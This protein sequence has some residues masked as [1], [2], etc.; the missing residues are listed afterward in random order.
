MGVSI[1][2]FAT[3]HGDQ[4]EKVHWEVTGGSIKL[5]SAY[6]TKEILRLCSDDA[7]ECFNQLRVMIQ[8]LTGE[9]PV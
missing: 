3:S 1:G 5:W 8:M 9:D 7:L 4:V 6:E 2:Y